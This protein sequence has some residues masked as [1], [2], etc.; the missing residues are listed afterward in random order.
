[1]SYENENGFI[2]C[3]Q[4][5]LQGPCQEGQQ[6]ILPDFEDPDL[7][8]TCIPTDCPNNQVRYL[9]ICI[10]V[11]T[12]EPQEVVVFNA[13]E[14]SATCADNLS[15]RLISAEIHCK[16]GQIKNGIG[17]CVNVRTP[18]RSPNRR[19]TLTYGRVRNLRSFI[20]NRR[21]FG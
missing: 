1:M 8:P 14:T 18:G 15:L 16:D 21:R 9:N 2:Q 3:Y 7:E 6:F 17:E 11:K 12:C 20:L 4:E 19:S 5:Y 10:P 13:E